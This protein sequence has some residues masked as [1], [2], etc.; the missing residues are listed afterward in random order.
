VAAGSHLDSVVQGGA[1]DGALGVVASLLAIDELKRRGI[2]PRRL[3]TVVVFVG[4]EGGRFG[5]PTMGSRLM[6]GSLRPADILDRTDDAET[7]LASTVRTTGVYPDTMGA[8]PGRVGLFRACVE[9]HI[10]QGRRLTNLG[11]SLDTC[12]G[13]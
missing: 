6:T 13:T 3:L 10:E 1:Y 4:E 8:D 5:V 11:V 9:L 7:T 12:S 2:A